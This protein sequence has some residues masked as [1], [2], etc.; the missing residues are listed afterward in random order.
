MLSRSSEQVHLMQ[1]Q[2]TGTSRLKLTPFWGLWGSVPPK[3]AL[4]VPRPW[5][6][7]PIHRCSCKLPST[8]HRDE[9]NG[10]L[11]GSIICGAVRRLPVVSAVCFGFLSG[12]SQCPIEQ[13]PSEQLN[14]RRVRR[15]YCTPNKASGLFRTSAVG[16]LPLSRRCHRRG[17]STTVPPF[18]LMI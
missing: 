13:L 8:C 15:V 12:P 14:P 9:D 18:I 6:S 11:I 1:A 4:D 3:L 2:A 7:R 5:R 10:T 17:R 16:F